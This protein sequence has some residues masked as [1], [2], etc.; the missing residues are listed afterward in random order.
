MQP[1]ILGLQAD[2]GADQL[3]HRTQD[4]I[5]AHQLFEGSDGGP[6]DTLSV[7]VGTAADIMA[8]EAALFNAL[9]EYGIGWHDGTIG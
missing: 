3:A 6:L 2:I 7:D 4:Q 8:F 5:V 9:D 1:A